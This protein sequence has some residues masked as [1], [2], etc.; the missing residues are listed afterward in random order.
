[1]QQVMDIKR[2][3]RSKMTD[4]YPSPQQKGKNVERK[5]NPINKFLE[6]GSTDLQ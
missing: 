4:V 3:G 1:M 6:C 5:T 2:K